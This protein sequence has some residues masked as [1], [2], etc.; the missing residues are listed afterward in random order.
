MV[1]HTFREDVPSG[2][3]RLHEVDED[4]FKVFEFDVMYCLELMKAGVPA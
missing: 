4:F 1:F 3:L 2:E